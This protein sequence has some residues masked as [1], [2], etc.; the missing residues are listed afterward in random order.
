M[1]LD[2]PQPLPEGFLATLL[3]DSGLCLCLDYDGT[4]AELAATPEIALP[5]PGVPADLRRLARSGA[6]VRLAIVTGRRVTEIKTLIGIDQGLF[7]S[8][9]HGMEIDEPGVGPRPIPEAISCGSEL[10]AV[11][12]WLLTNVPKECGFKIED[13]QIAIGLHYRLAEP[14]IAAEVCEQLAHFVARHTP[15]LK[16]MRLKMLAEAMPQIASKGRAV[17]DWKARVAASR[18]TVYMGDDATDEDAFA[19][20]CGSDFGVLVGPTRP[21]A[22][23][24]SLASPAAVARELHLLADAACLTRTVK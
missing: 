11:R 13:K 6:D 22:A 10:A 3:R 19:V 17:L 20:L 15:R 23:R 2:V 16:L 1:P 14:D 21:T 12:E 18:T 4:L 7:F 5:Y 8:G 9:V 24:Y